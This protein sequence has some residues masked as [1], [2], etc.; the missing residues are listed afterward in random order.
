[1]KDR[2]RQ[3][4]EGMGKGGWGKT[5]ETDAGL[6]GLNRYKKAWQVIRG[7]VESWFLHKD[8]LEVNCTLT[9]PLLSLSLR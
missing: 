6:A 7:V 2:M 5:S 8:N 9:A 4:D 3:E 1:M